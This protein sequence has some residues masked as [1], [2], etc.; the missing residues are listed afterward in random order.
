MSI[1]RLSRAS[2]RRAAAARW[3]LHLRQDRV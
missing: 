1:A 3:L 2:Q